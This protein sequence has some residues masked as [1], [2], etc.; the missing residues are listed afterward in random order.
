MIWRILYGFQ[1]QN[2]NTFILQI[3]NGIFMKYHL[4]KSLLVALGILTFMLS[5][6]DEGQELFTKLCSP[7]HTVGKGRLVGPDLKNISDIRSPEWLTSFIQSSQSLINSGDIDAVAIYKEYNNLLMPDQPVDA[8]QVNA[9]IVYIK[10][11]GSGIS[12]EGSQELAVDLLENATPQ[13]IIDGRQ[14]FSGKTRLTNGGASCISCHKVKDD[15]VFSSGTLAKDLTETHE[16]MG[17]AGVS[18]IISNPPFP[19]MAVTYAKNKLTVDE[20]FNLTAYLQWVS[21]E[22]YYQHPVS[23]G[24][25]FVIFGIIIFIMLLLSIIVLYFKRKKK[26]VNH[27]ILNRQSPVIN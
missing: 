24:T 9:I 18:A 23:F 5:K 11:A 6:A 16:I 21:K 8:G 27:E 13:N 17:S 14:I 2:S 25:T 19:A 26:S 3:F 1:I 12:A 7:C 10:E 22:R 20:V 15:N 4:K